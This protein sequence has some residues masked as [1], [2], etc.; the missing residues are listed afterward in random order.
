MAPT[1]A[2]IARNEFRRLGREDRGVAVMFVLCL[3]LFLYVLCASVW[4]YGENVR[5]RVELQNACDAAAYSAAVVQAD[6][7]SRM[8]VVNRAMSWSYVQMTKMQMD[9]ITLRWLEL[10]KERYEQDRR[11]ASETKL[12][13]M[14]TNKAGFHSFSKE[15]KKI[16]VWKVLRDF[17][18]PIPV[19]I[20]YDV[21]WIHI[22]FGLY[23]QE[24][25]HEKPLQPDGNGSYIGFRTFLDGMGS[26]RIEHIRINAPTRDLEAD[27][28]YLAKSTLDGSINPLQALYGP[29]GS[30][31]GP[32]IDAMKNLI[33]SFNALLP[34]LNRQ[35]AGAIEETAVRTL[36]EN[37][38]R[39]ENGLVDE[40][41]LRDCHWMVAGGASRPPEQYASGLGNLGGLS[42]AM[43]F[44]SAPY[45]SGLNNTEEDELVFLNMADGL[46]KKFGSRKNRNVRLVD[47]FADGVDGTA[48]SAT[49]PGVAAGLDQ[50]FIRCDPRESAQSDQV[51]VNRSFESVRGGIVRAYKNANYDE[52]ASEGSWIQQNLLAGFGTGIHRGNYVS[53]LTDDLATDPANTAFQ[54]LEDVLH[55]LGHLSS[56]WNIGKKPKTKHRPWNLPKKWKWEGKRAAR[57]TIARV[58]DPMIEKLL[59]PVTGT[60]ERAHRLMTSALKQFGS[61]DVKPSCVNDRLR[62]VDKCKNVRNTT[63]LVSEWQWASSYWFCNWC[64]VRG[65]SEFM[66][67]PSKNI[68]FQ[69][70]MHPHLPMAA[71]HGG[72]EDAKANNPIHTGKGTDGYPGDFTELAG[73]GIPFRWLIPEIKMFTKKGHSRKDYHASFVFLDSDVPE[74]CDHP[75]GLYGRRSNY[76]IK[77]FS[78]VYGDDKAVYDGRYQGVPCQPWVLNKKFFEGAGSIVVGVSRKQRNIFD[79]LFPDR[80]AEIESPQSLYSAFNPADARQNF[81]ALSVGRA[82]Y[83]PRMGTGRADGPDS[84]DAGSDPARVFEVR[85]DSVLDRK[86]GG[87][88]H[89]P[90]LPDVP[91]IT[92]AVKEQVA[93]IGR[94]GC[95]CGTDNTTHRLRHQ[96]NL[97]Q[98]DWDGVLLPLRHAHAK[99]ESYDS[100]D[101]RFGGDGADALSA[102]KFSPFGRLGD[103]DDAVSSVVDGLLWEHARWRPFDV[104]ARPGRAWMT[105]EEDDR[106]FPTEK[107]LPLPSDLDDAS[108]A[109]LF[110]KRRIL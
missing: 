12:L 99:H 88:D 20:G 17:G 2:G 19:Y 87:P 71:M 83:A 18:I 81:V 60:I 104:K 109:D 45:F 29:G 38:P 15:W 72:R 108:S 86:L 44:S 37:L 41:V 49:E 52:G 51:V 70:C 77:G 78:R 27:E 65:F 89:R 90:D 76:V 100:A 26:D 16:P 34:T 95:V 4:F 105:G 94:I 53:D 69:W 58:I 55:Q 31:L 91:G 103:R 75:L 74:S 28:T 14:F 98:T 110:R 67:F 80:T 63:G 102:W 79:E 11:N 96:W 92:P 54:P 73:I 6:G 59:E 97:S 43:C 9:Y 35:M 10:T 85:Y 3:F 106:W 66:L 1:V 64:K 32:V 61:L 42:D 93:G 56:M 50:W 46:P 48:K 39:D 24:G 25:I 57:D 107:I 8:A 84:I 13:D 21:L 30:L 23:C 101:R 22:Q 47:Y 33:V 7:L 68:L 82:G 36:F 5:R 40:A 62:F